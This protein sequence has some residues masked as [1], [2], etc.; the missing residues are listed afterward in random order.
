[1]AV[2]GAMLALGVTPV[3]AEFDAAPDSVEFL[4]LVGVTLAFLGVG[5]LFVLPRGFGTAS[6]CHGADK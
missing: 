6:G 2:V 4:G 5:F 1:M 3:T